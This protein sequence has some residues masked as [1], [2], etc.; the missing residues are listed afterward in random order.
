MYSNF[1]YSYGEKGG[2]YVE[3]LVHVGTYMYACKHLCTCVGST[4][5]QIPISSLISVSLYV[6]S[7][8]VT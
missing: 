7:C 4:Y 6:S 1:A 8:D 5:L 2:K 3:L